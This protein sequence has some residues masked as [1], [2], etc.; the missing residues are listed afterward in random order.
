MIVHA[1]LKLKCMEMWNV[2][3]LSKNIF[4]WSKNFHEKNIMD[5]L[6][7]VYPNNM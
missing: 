2:S 3:H 7:H 6:L 1:H 4:M 5:I